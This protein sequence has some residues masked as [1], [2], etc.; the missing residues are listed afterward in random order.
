MSLFLDATVILVV[1]LTAI[2]GFHKG[3]VKYVISMLGTVASVIVAFVASDFLTAPVYEKYV[4]KPL[5]SAVQSVVESV[6]IV[7]VA[8]KGFENLGIKISESEIQKI[9]DKGGNLIDNVSEYVKKNGGGA[10]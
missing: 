7:P 1:A 9:L 3:F 4:E 10:V 8:K 5:E 2:A 6:D